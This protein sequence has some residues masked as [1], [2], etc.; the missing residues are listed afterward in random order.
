[1]HADVLD[2]SGGCARAR[3]LC[4]R[5]HPEQRERFALERAVEY[6]PSC[7]GWTFLDLSR[8][9]CERGPKSAGGTLDRRRDVVVK[10][11]VLDTAMLDRA[12]PDCVNHWIHHCS[13]FLNIVRLPSYS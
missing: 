4:K 1:M 6:A 3:S 12:H 2:I 9:V 13:Y 7:D 8:G 11:M 5:E 10:L